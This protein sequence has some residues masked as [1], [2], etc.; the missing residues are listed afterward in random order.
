MGGG[1]SVVP[2]A[3]DSPRPLVVV[4]E[5]I[6]PEARA[7]LGARCEV[8]EAGASPGEE[9]L[10]G[11][12]GLVVR[13]YT[14]V[15]EA[16]LER[17]PRLRVVGR[18]GVGIDHIDLRACAR[19]GVRVVHTPEAN[20]GA[21]AELV[22]ASVLGAIRPMA[23]V[24]EGMDEG[25]WRALREACVAGSMLEG[26]T[27]GVWGLGR[28]GR[29]VARAGRAFGMRTIF[30]DLREIP[31]SEREGAAPVSLETLLAQ[32]DVL[33]VHVDGR[34]G[35][36]DLIGE[37]SFGRMKRDVVFVN[38]SRGF[39]VD[40]RACAAFLRSNEGARAILDV[41]RHEPVRGDSG[42]LGLE[43]AVLLPHLGSA[44]TPAKRAMS[45]VVRDV[46]RVLRGEAP[47]FE[48][49]VS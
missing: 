48:A 24:R 49:R 14:P 7:W 23:R 26:S 34:E 6:D 19:R 25:A 27:L 47:A 21:V 43:N 39:V 38:M 8:I 37:Q 13:T 28:V 41:H 45:W 15:D 2:P 46:V 16:L 29:R 11:A 35:N 22:F 36:R 12:E 31:E 5:P 44:T 17:A 33:S 32:S 30:H 9:A 1:E 10:A 20:A 3:P 42:L 40:E 18:A 4:C